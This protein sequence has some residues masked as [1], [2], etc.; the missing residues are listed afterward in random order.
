MYPDEAWKSN[1]RGTQN[2][3]TAAA[4]SGV[5]VFVNISTEKAADPT[6][7]L[8][9]SISY[10]YGLQNTGSVVT[11]VVRHRGSAVD[12]IAQ[13][14]ADQGR[15]GI[16]NKQVATRPSGTEVGELEFRS[17]AVATLQ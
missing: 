5:D 7:V 9:R 14:H 15:V 16:R 6:S 12:D 17:F 1:V 3:I 4:K 2:V 8:G 11:R 13:V 10:S